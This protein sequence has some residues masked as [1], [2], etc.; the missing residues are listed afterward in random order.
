MV[1]VKVD[2]GVMITNRETGETE[3]RKFYTLDDFEAGNKFAEVNGAIIEVLDCEQKDF[4][5]KLVVKFYGGLML[6]IST[7]E[8]DVLTTTESK[9]RLPSWIK[10]GIVIYDCKSREDLIIESVGLHRVNLR[11]SGDSDLRYIIMNTVYTERQ[12]VV[13]SWA[14]V[15]AKVKRDGLWAEI[16]TIDGY[17]A[18]IR[19]QIGAGQTCDLDAS[20]NE[21]RPGYNEHEYGMSCEEIEV[22]ESAIYY[23]VYKGTPLWGK[24]EQFTKSELLE[25]DELRC[26]SMINSCLIYGTLY[27]FYDERNDRF[28]RYGKD[29]EEKL[30]YEL[31]LKLLRAQQER[32]KHAKVGYA[33]TDHEGVSYNYCKWDVA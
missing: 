2:N 17:M 6:V 12:P 16:L 25:L 20:I 13:P 21:L 27:D 1:R 31:T 26:R 9:R 5:C 22:R 24:Q 7:A 18:K 32:F 10:R 33:G 28:V 4:G 8:H 15:G 3:Y 19:L 11:Y 29:Y 30:G 14:T 23:R